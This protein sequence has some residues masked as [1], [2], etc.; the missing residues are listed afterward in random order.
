MDSQA[1]NGINMPLAFLGQEYVW[2]E[3][4]VSKFGL[5]VRHACWCWC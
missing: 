2:Q 1:L 5:T 4:F 3:L